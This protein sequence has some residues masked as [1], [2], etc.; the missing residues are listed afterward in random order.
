MSP[1]LTLTTPC[2]RLRPL[3]SVADQ[4]LVVAGRVVVARVEQGDAGV[5]R[6]LDRGDR[7]RLVGG[8]V[9]VGHAHAA[10]PERGDGRPVE[11]SERVVTRSSWSLSQDRLT[12]KVQILSVDMES[13]TAA[14]VLSAQSRGTRPVR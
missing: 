4:Q 7:L 9:E 12:D 10:E 1:N 5:E 6:G 11:P 3:Q 14:T 2:S 13:I 8:A